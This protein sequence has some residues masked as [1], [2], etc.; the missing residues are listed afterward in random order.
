M[1]IFGGPFPDFDGNGVSDA[2]DFMILDDLIKEDE[3][4]A[5]R[6]GFSGPG[7]S[8]DDDDNGDDDLWP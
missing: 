1:G 2:F 7:S 8:P 5:R 4:E 3:R 6:S